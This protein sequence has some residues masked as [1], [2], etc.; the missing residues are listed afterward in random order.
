M[1]P[2]LITPQ[3]KIA[4]AKVRKIREWLRKKGRIRESRL[5][6]L[7]SSLA[8]LPEIISLESGEESIA[9]LGHLTGAKAAASRLQRR[10]LLFKN[11]ALCH[12]AESGEGFMET[13]RPT[14]HIH[15]TR[16]PALYP[17][18][19]AINEPAP[20]S[21]MEALKVIPNGHVYSKLDWLHSTTGLSWNACAALLI[22]NGQSKE[23]IGDDV[24]IAMENARKFRRRWDDTRKMYAAAV[25]LQQAHPAIG[26]WGLI[27]HKSLPLLLPGFQAP[28]AQERDEYLI[29]LIENRVGIISKPLTEYRFHSLRRY[30]PLFLLT[31]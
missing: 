9:L 25:T 27:E 28:K 12:I 1:N 7:F 2:T 20:M 14:R 30:N 8:S 22:K 15:P 3:Q 13:D 11:P 18:L 24:L 31:S 23:A 4:N 16:K 17:W 21:L 19:V 29:R 26:Q 6:P 10:A 5:T